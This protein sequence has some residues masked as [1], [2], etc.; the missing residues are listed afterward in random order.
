MGSVSSFQAS[1]S[2]ILKC[3]PNSAIPTVSVASSCECP[4]SSLT[5]PQWFTSTVTTPDLYPLSMS[6]R[7]AMAPE[8][9][10][11]NRDRQAALSFVEH[12]CH[13]P[14]LSPQE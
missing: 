10:E 3:L 2:S 14:L 8:G 5:P 7:S 13:E 1:V 9:V 11:R 4:L 6:E 12:L